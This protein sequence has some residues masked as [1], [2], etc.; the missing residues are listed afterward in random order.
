MGYIVDRTKTKQGKAR[1]WLLVSAPML[2]ISGILLFV[3]PDAGET[4]QVVWI[5]LTYNLYYSIAFTIYNMSH[6][7]R[8]RCP[9]EIWRSGAVCPYS[10]ISLR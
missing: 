4:V 2:M 10:I 6:N 9:Q 7:L 8:C 1:P 5:M 3:V